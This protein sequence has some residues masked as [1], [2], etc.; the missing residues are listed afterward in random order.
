MYYA[1]DAFGGQWGGWGA[2]VWENICTTNNAFFEY[3]EFDFLNKSCSPDRVWRF[4]GA[5]PYD[6]P[7]PGMTITFVP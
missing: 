7:S 1:D 3:P 2:E 4:W 5:I 6:S